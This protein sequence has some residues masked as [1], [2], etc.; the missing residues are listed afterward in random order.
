MTL[1]EKNLV[2]NHRFLPYNVGYNCLN[3]NVTCQIKSHEIWYNIWSNVYVKLYKTERLVPNQIF[4]QI[5]E[6]I[7]NEI[8]R[9]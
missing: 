6:N 9:K 4:N 3:S 2:V 5:K 7:I 8:N 1:T